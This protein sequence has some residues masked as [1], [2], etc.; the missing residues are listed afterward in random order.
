MSVVAS[1]GTY[2]ILSW[3][4]SADSESGIRPRE[5]FVSKISKAFGT[6]YIF[7]YVPGINY[8]FM[9]VATYRSTVRRQSEHQFGHHYHN[10][11][12]SCVK[13]ARWGRGQARGTGIDSS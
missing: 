13:E 4:C 1:P 12:I 10:T 9:S 6:R 7:S 8:P 3:G 5:N 11:I 2:L